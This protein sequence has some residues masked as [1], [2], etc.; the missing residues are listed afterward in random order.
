[1]TDN[2]TFLKKVRE[3]YGDPAKRTK[4]NYAV[5]EYGYR[6]GATSPNAVCWCFLGAVRKAGD[7]VL[8]Y[9]GNESERA[10]ERV[11]QGCI[12]IPDTFDCFIQ[13]VINLNDEIEGGQ[14][15]LL[16]AVDCAIAKLETQVQG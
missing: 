11:A 5:D 13:Y 2:L 16:A 1:M 8:E 15:Q 9:M 6:C 14:D 10:W 7:E 4:G 12:T 3:I